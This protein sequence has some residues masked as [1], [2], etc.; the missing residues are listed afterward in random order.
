MSVAVVVALAMPADSQVRSFGHG[1]P[2][3]AAGPNHPHSGFGPSEH[4]HRFGTGVVIPY[5][6]PYPVPSGAEAYPEAEAPGAATYQNSPESQPLAIPPGNWAPPLIGPTHR[7]EN[8]QPVP[9][10][11]TASARPDA[12]DPTQI[13]FLIALKNHWVYTA[14]AYWLQGPILHYITPQGVHNQV[15]LSL[16]DFRTSTKLNA[17]RPGEFALPAP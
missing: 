17:G 8:L 15:S 7:E 11:Q 3:T 1:A 9:N 2:P 12:P 5:F 10:L 6:I 4:P 16:I 13:V 14:I